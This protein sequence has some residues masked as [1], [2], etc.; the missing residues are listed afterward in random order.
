MADD[1]HDDN[2]IGG[3]VA[4]SEDISVSRRGIDGDK[5]NLIDCSEGNLFKRKNVSSD[6]E[7]GIVNLQGN[8]YSQNNVIDS[9]G[10]SYDLNFQILIVS[11]KLSALFNPQHLP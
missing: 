11:E 3:A 8:D 6:P 7:A 10:N 2:E 9:E 1:Y 4:T 5:D